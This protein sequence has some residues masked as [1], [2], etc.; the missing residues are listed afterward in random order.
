MNIAL[1][2]QMEM[3]RKRRIGTGYRKKDLV[4]HLDAI[5]NTPSGH[6]NNTTTWYD[7]AGNMNITMYNTTWGT[8]YCSF[9]GNINSYGLGA[10]WTFSKG[11]TIEAVFNLQNN[12][13]IQYPVLA[14]WHKQLEE[15]S[16]APS[17]LLNTERGYVFLANPNGRYEITSVPAINQISMFSASSLVAS[18]NGNAYN[19]NITFSGFTETASTFKIGVGTSQ[20]SDIPISGTQFKGN[21]YAV[22]VYDANLT[23]NELYAHWLI[24]KKRFNIP[25]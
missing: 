18:L 16:V 12:P 24:D 9:A 7:L 4:L 15:S 3:I 20:S 22:R 8:D 21:I 1:L 17:I 14:G 23:A 25:D 19:H 10:K 13:G 2:Y 11:I 5:D 6:S